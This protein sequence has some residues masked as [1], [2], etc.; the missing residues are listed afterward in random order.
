M[1]YDFT[2]GSIPKKL[3]KFTIP[4][5]FALILQQLYGAVDLFMVGNFANSTDVSAV[6]TGFQFISIFINLISGLSMGTTI[7][8]GHKLGAKKSD[9]V[10]SVIG[11]GLFVFAIIAIIMT[12]AIGLNGDFFSSIIKAPQEAFSKTSSYISILAFGSVFLVGYNIIG[13]IFRGLGDSTTPLMAVSIATVTNIIL[14]YIFIARLGQGA[15]GAAIATVIA[16]AISVLF[17]LVVIY[18]RDNQYNFS[19][20][21]IRYHSLYTKKTLTLGTPVAINAFLV[22]ISFTFVLRVV[23]QLGVSVSAGVGVTERLIGFLMLIPMAFGQSMASY[24]SQNVGANQHERARKGLLIAMLISLI[25]AIITIF[26]SLSYGD[27]MLGIFSNDPQIITPAFEYLKSY[28]FDIFF[29]V[30]LFNSIGYFNGYGKTTFT[31]IS[32]VLGAFLFRIPLSYAFSLITPTSIFLIGLA[33][34]IGTLF[35]LV[36][37]FIYYRSLRKKIRTE[38]FNSPSSNAEGSI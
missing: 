8:I 11:A 2:M 27:K 1:D 34:P 30:F 25:V 35:Q 14:D 29:T 28:C 21:Y 13:S 20:K 7:L 15:K 22:S 18:K 37:S 4:I 5:L 9:S 36:I 12:F 38:P 33:T 31:M 10:G 19:L 24:T 26:I 6:S 3:I 17:S 16:Q 23:N 32:G